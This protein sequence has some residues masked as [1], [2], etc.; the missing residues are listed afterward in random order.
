[1]EKRVG[2]EW[3]TYSPIGYYAIQKTILG[4]HPLDD[5]SLNK[6]IFIKRDRIVLDV[7]FKRNEVDLT[8]LSLEIK[9]EEAQFRVEGK[10]LKQIIDDSIFGE[11]S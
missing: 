4:K 2:Q 9:R 10:V 6:V 7:T 11:G 3:T 5:D 1:M 8:Q